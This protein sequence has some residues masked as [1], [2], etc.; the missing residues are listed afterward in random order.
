M[1]ADA[2]RPSWAVFD[3]TGECYA[4]RRTRAAALAS[5]EAATEYLDEA[6]D[7]GHPGAVRWVAERRP[8][9]VEPL[10]MLDEDRV[11]ADGVPVLDR[12]P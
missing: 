6:L 9:H 12:E 4:I 1:I 7:C 2:T 3:A 11:R 8:L 5:M 10:S